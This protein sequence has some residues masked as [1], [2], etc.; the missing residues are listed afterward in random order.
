MP[1]ERLT[2]LIAEDESIIRLGLK[3]MLEEM[4]HTVIAAS[5]GLSA[6]ELAR[7]SR[8][9]LAVLDVRM[10]GL[11]GIQAAEAIVAEQPM[12]IIL[13]TAY[14]DH[15]V[16]QRARSAS[17]LA[18]LVKPLR[19]ETLRPTIELA[20]ARFAAHQALAEEREDMA[21]ALVTR[22]LVEQAKRILMERDGLTEAEAFQ[23]IQRDSRA[24][25]R[26]MRVT[27]E[28]IVAGASGPAGWL[29]QIE[30]K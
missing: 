14:S 22:D 4:G 13:L 8:P 30:S 29:G 17:I 16:I 7:Q 18:Y 26:S 28:A 21:Q 12:P 3:R 20:R 24:S 1:D 6:V 27:A 2:I 25:R 9:D 5:D 15:K 23:R 10:P 11:D 19:E